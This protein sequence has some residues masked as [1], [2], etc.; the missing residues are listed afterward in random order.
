MMGGDLK[1]IGDVWYEVGEYE[2]VIECYTAAAAYA[3]VDGTAEYVELYY[4]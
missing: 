4:V 3:K 1:V 2:K